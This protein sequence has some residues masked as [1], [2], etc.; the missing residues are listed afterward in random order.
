M[1]GR[2]RE[3]QGQ[4]GYEGLCR[5]ERFLMSNKPHGRM[6]KR[7]THSQAF[8]FSKALPLH[9]W[10]NICA[11]PPP[12]ISYTYTSVCFYGSDDAQ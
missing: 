10:S 12:H 5:T 2:Q 4:G 6:V 3:K 9:T 7:R 8:E 11:H 1:N